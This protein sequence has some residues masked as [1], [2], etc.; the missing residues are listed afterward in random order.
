M[1][2]KLA[3]GSV[4]AL[5]CLEEVIGPATLNPFCYPNCYLAGLQ[6]E[7]AEPDFH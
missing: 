7:A 6:P 4:F 2:P 1:G 3:L 5:N